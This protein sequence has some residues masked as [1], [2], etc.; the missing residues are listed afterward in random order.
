MYSE[1]NG[2][3]EPL[4]VMRHGIRG[5][6]NVNKEGDEKTSAAGESKARDVSNIQQTDTAKL[7]PEA[8]A[9]VVKFGISFLPVS[10]T[11]FASAMATGEKDEAEYRSFLSSLEDFVARASQSDGLTEVANRYARNILNG[12]WLWRNRTIAK[13]INVTVIQGDVVIADIDG[14]SIPMNHFND[15]SEAEIALGQVIRDGLSGDNTL[16]SIA[17]RARVVFPV[18]GAVEVFPSQN[19]LETK[20]K[21][22][23]RPLYHLKV[24]VSKSENDIQE[25]GMAAI[26]DQKIGNAIRTFDTWYP[27]FDSVKKPI[28]VEPNGASLDAKRFFRPV[29][30]RDSV[31]SFKIATKL[32]LIDPNSNEGMFMI[33]SLIRGGVYSGG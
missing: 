29:S 30:G 16:P 14:L 13:K 24:G 18:A 21:G 1:V 15:Y 4:M 11:L 32:N 19:Y 7:H 6:Q 25:I 8:S 33:A 28:P 20:A 23:A 2:Q 12:R 27:D 3:L 22:F 10:D 9:L 31:S 17:I 5:T 26:R